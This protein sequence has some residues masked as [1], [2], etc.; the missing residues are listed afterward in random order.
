MV[1]PK[2]MTLLS[3][4]IS[5]RENGPPLT[6]SSRRALVG[7][8]FLVSLDVSQMDILFFFFFCPCQHA[9]CP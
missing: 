3:E 5:L 2:A 6:H 7:V 8:I 4:I 9:S 1:V